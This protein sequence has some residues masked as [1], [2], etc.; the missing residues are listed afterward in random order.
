MHRN[1]IFTDWYILIAQNLLSQN[2][3]A[4]ALNSYSVGVDLTVIICSSHI[5]MLNK[6]TRAAF[7]KKASEENSHAVS[8]ESP[9]CVNSLLL[10]HYCGRDIFWL[11]THIMQ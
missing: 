6:Q 4:G 11:L 1:S 8:T 10:G 9:Y 7:C 2:R 5:C 3:T